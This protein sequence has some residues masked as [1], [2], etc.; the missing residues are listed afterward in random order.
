MVTLRIE[1][2]VGLMADLNLTAKNLN[3]REGWL[4]LDFA[5]TVDWHASDHPGEN[6]NSY[7]DLIAWAENVGLLTAQE[8]KHLLREAARRPDDAALTLQQAVELRE[9][10][11]QV[12][13]A[14]ARGTAP[15]EAALSQLNAALSTALA[16]T[17]IVPTDDGY[18]WDWT[19]DSETLEAVLWP[20]ARSA[21]ELLT[22]PDLDRVGE[23][24][25]D[26]GCGWLFFDTTRNH[27]RRWCFMKDCG[28]R[29]KA[30]RHYERSRVRTAT[31]RR[32]AT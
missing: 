5:N 9:A 28:N 15:G 23:C 17:R 27:S 32:K 16:H 20:V 10:I 7:A 11:Y 21:A 24:A 12:C 4:C 22:S 26:R 31:R 2:G 3:L 13:S 18:V 6:L 1:E 8:S 19:G 14:V 29:A 25:D 30:H